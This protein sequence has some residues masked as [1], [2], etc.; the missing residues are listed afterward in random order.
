MSEDVHDGKVSA[1]ENTQDKTESLAT[2]AQS[3]ETVVA[4]TVTVNDS[5]PMANALDN[6]TSVVKNIKDNGKTESENSQKNITSLW[7][8]AYEAVRSTNISQLEILIKNGFSTDLRDDTGKTLLIY[9]CEHGNSIAVN[10]LLKNGFDVNSQDLEGLTA[11]Y[12][13]A[14]HRKYESV[15]MLLC[16]GANPNL[17]TKKGGTPI[18]L[19]AYFGNANQ[20]R[21]LLE[22]G[23]DLNVKL[24]DGKAPL[25]MALD[26]GKYEAAGVLI[27]NNA[28]FDK[29][30]SRIGDVLNY[31][32]QMRLFEDATTIIK[33]VPNLIN[34]QDSAGDTYLH[35]YIVKRDFTTVKF[36]L[37]AGANPNIKN[38]DKYTPHDI[39]RIESHKEMLVLLKKHGGKKSGTELR[40]KQANEQEAPVSKI[41]AITFADVGGMDELKHKLRTMLIAPMKDKQ[42]AKKYG[43]K[44]GGGVLLHGAPG[45]GKTLIARAIAGEVN[46]PF[47]EVRY[48]DIVSMWV[49][50]SEHHLAAVFEQA[51]KMAPCVLFF[52]EVDAIGGGRDLTNGAHDRHLLNVFLTELD[53]ASSNNEGILVIGATNRIDIVDQALLRPGR[54]GRHVHVQQPDAKAR[55][56]IF[57]VHLKGMPVG[58]IDYAK[59]AKETEGYS[60]ATIAS[61]CEDAL[62]QAYSESLIGKNEKPVTEELLF[63]LISKSKKA[64][65]MQEIKGDFR[66]YW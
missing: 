37:E 66:H 33:L 24:P 28:V 1:A 52:D 21:F 15:N 64:A 49:G 57:K 8:T 17:K 6:V 61:T 63:G 60:G 4:E 26:N 56:E 18:F 2:P 38:K 51:R 30:D 22:K 10:T 34:I 44:A 12:I 40:K 54:L 13:A 29:K 59:L 19:S 62:M 7:T 27:T 5:V 42:L 55:E 50:E 39:A 35:I 11:L 36:L 65:G 46:L 14:K 48:S 3:K 45:C 20:V 58:K 41:K 23:A 47:L 53:G 43:V 16:A 32:L 25:D 31:H 9:A